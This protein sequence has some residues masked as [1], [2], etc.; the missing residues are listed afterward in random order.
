MEIANGAWATF[1]ARHAAIAGG[2]SQDVQKADLGSKG[3]W[4]RLRFGP[5]A[6]KAS[7]NAACDK[8]RAEGGTCFVAP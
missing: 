6:D 4:Y 8:L 7:A 3:T 1:K 2:L 5:F